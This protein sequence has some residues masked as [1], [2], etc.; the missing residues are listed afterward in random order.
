MF[1]TPWLL[2]LAAGLPVYLVAARMARRG[3]RRGIRL[4]L[5]P[6]GGPPSPDAPLAW[7]AALV[8]S[9]LAIAASWI[10]VSVAAAGPVLVERSPVPFRSELD[11][12]FVV[13]VSPSMAAMDLEP[14]RLEAAIALVRDFLSDAQGAAGASVGLVAFGAE[15]S[16]ICPPTRDYTILDELL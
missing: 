8:L 7:R 13:D 3:G 6:W 15:A 5:D 4:P 12:V 1:D 9:A 10:A 11:I 2:L 16:L 14:T